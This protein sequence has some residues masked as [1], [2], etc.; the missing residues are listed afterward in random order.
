MSPREAYKI[1]YG[2]FT[3]RRY[4]LVHDFCFFK[5]FPIG[6]LGL[7]CNPRLY[8]FYELCK[9]RLRT[10]AD[11]VNSLALVP[12]QALIRYTIDGRSRPARHWYV[13]PQTSLTSLVSLSTLM[14]AM[15]TSS[16]TESD[17]NL[18]FWMLCNSRRM[19]P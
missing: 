17:A 7:I 8:M 1:L 19:S 15:M 3:T 18:D 14:A 13:C 2:N 11:L 10:N 16:L 4:T 12:L 9:P 5:L 6:C